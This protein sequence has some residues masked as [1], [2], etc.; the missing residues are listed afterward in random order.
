MIIP[1]SKNIRRRDFIFTAAGALAA[2][3][4]PG[5][6]RA[7]D[8][9]PVRAFKNL[10]P[11]DE[12][13]NIACIGIG[14]QGSGNVRGV[15]SEN[16][17]AL[18]DVDFNR[19]AGNFR[20]LPDAARYRD[21]RQM[22][23][24]MGDQFDAVLISTPDH[25]HF[26]AAMMALERGKH[27][28]VEK[29]LTRTIGEVRLLREAAIRAG[30][31][32]Q[33]GNQGHANEGTRLVKEWIDAGAL[34][35]VT[36]LHAWTDRPVWPQG[37]T[38]LPKEVPVPAHLDWNLWLGTAPWVEFR[39]RLVPFD[40]R[41]YWDYGTGALG[42][43][44]C[45]LLDAGF[46]A[47]DLRG[48]VRVSAVSEGNSDITGPVWSV[49]TYEF[50]AR[51]DKPPI[52]VVWYEGKKKP[53][54]PPELEEDKELPDG[55]AIYRGDKGAMLVTGNYSDSPRLI[56]ET[57]M[58][59]FARPEKTIPRIHGGAIREW[60]NACKGGPVPG[61]NIVDH[62][63]ALTEFILLGNLAIRSGKPVDW[64]I[65]AGTYRGA[66]ELDALIN[67]EFRIF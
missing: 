58:K 64:H 37:F 18:C 27:I 6:L 54:R 53:E 7:Q 49:V 11:A 33:M 38:S 2:C 36:E 43:M 8:E 29:P 61:S 25:T 34:G 66:P 60:I 39:E 56:P 65:G 44:G 19:A 16:I 45:H 24:E 14:G 46:W 42:D 50:P 31:V 9:L 41:G 30:T 26:P 63:A 10:R 13:L 62:S 23:D 35:A 22:F 52:K 3:G 47:L 5:W 17:V 4:L 48:P 59:A 40:W 20:F 15:M 28:Y 21:Y 57:A 51:G 32:T 67:P 55:G 12:K 1:P